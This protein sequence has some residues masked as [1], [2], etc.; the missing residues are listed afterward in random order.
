MR[1]LF[2]SYGF[3]KDHLR[4]QPWRYVLEL[5]RGMTQSET[6]CAVLTDCS[7]AEVGD[8]Y[9]FEV[10]S[11]DSLHPRNFRKTLAA[12]RS[13]EPTV[14]LWPIGPKSPVFL[15]LLSQVQALK[16]GYFPGP[17]LQPGDHD[18]CV[19]HGVE[20]GRS[21]K[22]VWWPTRTRLWGRS[23]RWLCDRFIVQSDANANHLAKIGIPQNRIFTVPSGAD[24]DEYEMNRKFSSDEI[25]LLFMGWPLPIRGIDLL[26]DAFEIAGRQH[27][28]LR[29]KVLARGDGTEGHSALLRRVEQSAVQSQI[30]VV[31]GFLPKEDVKKHISQAD[32]GI[33]PFL[34]V[35]ADRPISFLELFSAGKPVVTTDATGLPELVADQRGWVAERTRENLAQAMSQV[36]ALTPHTYSLRSEACK[37][38]ISAYPTWSESVATFVRAIS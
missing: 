16:V 32:V 10:L 37:G 38:Y 27:P 6:S 1:V 4:L 22:V 36:A 14:I 28:N 3:K 24:V 13:Y 20:T 33:L 35:P 31:E 17:I 5:L 29:L 23:L 9:S 18:A 7:L 8:D 15:P 11:T 2:V 21:E 12:I 26:M 34:Q 19:R 30:R 25:E